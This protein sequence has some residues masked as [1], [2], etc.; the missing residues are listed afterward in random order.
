LKLSFQRVVIH[1]NR[2]PNKRVTPFLLH[3]CKLSRLISER[4]TPNDLVVTPC[5]G[6]LK[7]WISMRWKEDF[8]VLLNIQISSFVHLWTFA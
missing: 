1:P 8:V 3:Q 4:V 6:L 2:T 5:T 7:C